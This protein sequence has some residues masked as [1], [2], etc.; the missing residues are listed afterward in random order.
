[1]PAMV[2][3]RAPGIARAVAAPPVG[4]TIGRGRRG[5]P[6]SARRSGAALPSGRPRRRCLRVAGRHRRTWDRDP[7]RCPPSRAPTPR[8]TEIRARRCDGTCPPRLDRLATISRWFH[9]RHQP[10]RRCCGPADARRTGGRHD[11]GE[12]ADPARMMR[13][14]GLGDHSAHRD[15]DECAPRSPSASSRPTVSRAMSPRWYWRLSL[16]PRRI[17]NGL[18]PR[19][20]DGWTGRRRDCRTGSPGIPARR[21]WRPSPPARCASAVPARRPA[22]PAVRLVT[23]LVVAQLD[24]ATHV[25]DRFVVMRTPA[26][27]GPAP[28]SA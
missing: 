10:P 11:R 7:M 8:R 21:G 16:P 17:A 1:M 18:G 26:L 5:S 12:R 9:G 2:S 23:E 13:G 4:W 15:P 22:R 28:S 20:V 27:R 6:G 24:S 3:S 14:D 19:K 25:D